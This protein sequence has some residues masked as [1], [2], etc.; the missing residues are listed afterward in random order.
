MVG[1]YGPHFSSWG[2]KYGFDY[3]QEYFKK[4]CMEESPFEIFA[5]D[6]RS[7]DERYLDQE[8]RTFEV[9]TGPAVIQE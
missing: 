7:D 5:S 3:A 1:Y 2:I 9:N 6:K 4:C 8:K